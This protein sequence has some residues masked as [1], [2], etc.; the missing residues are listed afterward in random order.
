[1][2]VPTVSD[3]GGPTWSPC[4]DP[5]QYPSGDDPLWRAHLPRMC[6]WCVRK[7]IAGAVYDAAA[8]EMV[9]P[10]EQANRVRHAFILAEEYL[11]SVYGEV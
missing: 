1:M 5:G 9:W 6:Y 3:P 2:N 7:H 10:E 8:P 11:A 4:C